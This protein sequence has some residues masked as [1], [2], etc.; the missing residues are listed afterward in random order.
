MIPLKKLK[1]AY[2]FAENR[3]G[4]QKFI[5]KQKNVEIRLYCDRKKMGTVHFD[6][7]DFLSEK[8]SKR[9]F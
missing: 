6:I 2:F 7:M 4:V 1:I 8:V 3:E 5:E 9:Q